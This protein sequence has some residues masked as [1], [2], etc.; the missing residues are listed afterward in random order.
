MSTTLKG[1]Y[2]PDMNKITGKASCFVIPNS[3]GY[4]RE[5][6]SDKLRQR[7][8]GELTKYCELNNIEF[9]PEEDQLIQV[10]WHS[11]EYFDTDNMYRHGCSVADSDGNIYRF[12]IDTPEYMPYPL[13]KDVTEGSRKIIYVPCTI[14]SK[15]ETGTWESDEGKKHEVV[16]EVDMEF[17]QLHYR[18]S[19]FGNFEDVVKQVLR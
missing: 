18:Y 9:N 11:D 19:R 7:Y 6:L 12:H 3:A 5:F 17:D 4:C 16:L 1:L 14:F 2:D 13:I 8:T 15:E 10:W